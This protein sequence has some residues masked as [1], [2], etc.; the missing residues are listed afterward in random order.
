MKILKAGTRVVTV[1]GNI[2]AF[3]VGVNISM[4]TIDYKIRWFSN[5]EEKTA[6]LYRFEIEIAPVKQTAGFNSKPIIKNYDDE[7][8]LIEA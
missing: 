4:D 2:E 1:I 6:W 7:I 3:V 8:T 5:G